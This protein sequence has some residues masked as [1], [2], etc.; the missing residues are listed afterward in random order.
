MHPIPYKNVVV[1]E[2]DIN[3]LTSNDA[4]CH[5]WGYLVY[6]KLQ[7]VLEA[8]NWADRNF[9]QAT[10]FLCETT[11]TF[12]ISHGSNVSHKVGVQ[13]KTFCKKYKCPF[14]IC[15]FTPHFW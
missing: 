1:F 11:I 7:T 6:K 5:K 10:D 15:F 8:G 2:K 14:Q 4:V 12:L 3:A 9:N 13:L